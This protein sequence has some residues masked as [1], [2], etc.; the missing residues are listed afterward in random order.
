MVYKFSHTVRWRIMPANLVDPRIRQTG[1]ALADWGLGRLLAV[2]LVATAIFSS[3]CATT[4]P[5]TKLDFSL[6]N[7]SDSA[8]PGNIQAGDLV[9]PGSTLKIEQVV[10][11]RG[12]GKRTEL[13]GTPA[14][15]VRVDVYGGAFDS[16]T[17]EI[18]LTS[19]PSNIP[20]GGYRI[21]LT[22]ANGTASVT[23]RYEPDF[24]RIFGPE[25]GDIA[26]FDVQLD[27]EG[28]GVRYRLAEGTALIPG[29]SYSLYAEITDAR[30]R[31]FLSGDH[32][33]PVPVERFKTSVSGFTVTVDGRLTAKSDAG[34]FQIKV[35]YGSSEAHSTTLNFTYDAAIEKGPAP[36]DISRLRIIGELAR[37][38]PIGPGE[39]KSLDV[40]VRDNNGRIWRLDMEQN[41]SHKERVF[42]LRP[43]RLAIS[44]E[45][46]TYSNQSRRIQF[47]NDAKS[48]LGKHYGVNVAYQDDPSL[49]DSKTFTPDFLSIVP[50]MEGDEIVFTGRI[51]QTGLD[52][53]NGPPGSRGND[54]TREMG[55]GGQGRNGGH[56]TPGQTGGNGGQGPNV[57]VVAREVRTIDNKERLVLFEVRVPGKAPEHMM[58]LF[59][60]SPVLV[61]SEGG[62]GGDGGR[63]SDGGKGGDGGTGH[64]SGDG[65]D[66]GN[67]GVGGDG[68]AGGPGGRI[69][70]ILSAH[71]LE[72]AFILDSRGGAGGAGGEAGIAGMP[73]LPGKL[74]ESDKRR[75]SD[76]V[77]EVGAYGNEGNIGYTGRPGHAGIDG[78][79]QFRVDEPAA[80]AVV[81]RVP[82]ELRQVILY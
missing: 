59:S 8:Q 61:R 69:N 2:A 56:G 72:G 82:E 6:A 46:G 29:E 75:S 51:G 49:V 63:G 38:V 17:G 11:T 80:A 32:E 12:D 3:G 40:E 18:R 15:D 57:Q 27:W 20:A 70:V 43:S 4:S 25:P 55:R 78:E 50:L 35:Q 19:D 64:F 1:R 47:S 74:A 41:G 44:V 73:G 22:D 52:G 28:D 37:E 16:L 5:V 53:R 60:G 68:G 10:V 34:V 67:A 62:K 77:S 54:V 48:M 33:Y 71:V 36:S 21:T 76:A 30:G 42:R 24:A 7:L 14:T 39:S 66:G 31:T 45:N 9:L 13:A 23:E 65:G 81:G 79:V 58:R 26:E